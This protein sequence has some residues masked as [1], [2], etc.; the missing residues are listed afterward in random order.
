M[1]MAS[2]A[3]VYGYAMSVGLSCW[4]LL[5]K[6][7][8]QSLIEDHIESHVVTDRLINRA[9][10][11]QRYHR[12]GDRLI[13]CVRIQPSCDGLTGPEDHGPMISP[14]IH[15]G[16]EARRSSGNQAGQSGGAVGRSSFP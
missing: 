6:R 13:G 7:W 14:L 3:V 12:S 8:I 5:S 2:F 10:K 9:R 16:M 1:D 15:R 11:V 4:Q